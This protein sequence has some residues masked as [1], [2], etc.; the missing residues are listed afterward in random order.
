MFFIWCTTAGWGEM[1]I[2]T[3]TAT[4]IDYAPGTERPPEW[5][6]FYSIFMIIGSFFF[7]NLFVGVVIQTFKQ[8]QEKVG[9]N[10]LLTEK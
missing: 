2:Q 8:Q 9:G 3:I 7:I 6:T 10:E 4:Q 5:I 1:M